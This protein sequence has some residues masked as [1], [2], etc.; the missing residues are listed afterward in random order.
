[1]KDQNGS[2]KNWTQSFWRQLESILQFG[3]QEA[4]WLGWASLVRVALS[5]C[6]SLSEPW[7]V[8]QELLSGHG[9]PALFL[10]SASS[11]GEFEL[12][13]SL[14]QLNVKALTIIQALL[15]S[16]IQ[17]RIPVIVILSRTVFQVNTPIG[18]CSPSLGTWPYVSS[19]AVTVS[20][21]REHGLFPTMLP[22][23]SYTFSY[24]SGTVGTASPPFP[25]SSFC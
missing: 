10:F 11:R 13:D 4:D 14:R 9:D 21:C 1:M 22:L 12:V 23:P 18:V 2:M 5:Q 24:H 20:S 8:G 16:S 6:A 7:D 17:N 19:V 15:G 3:L 25:C